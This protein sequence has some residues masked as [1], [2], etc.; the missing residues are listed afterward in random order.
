MKCQSVIREFQ[1]LVDFECSNTVNNTWTELSEW[2][3]FAEHKL[4]L[5][6]GSEKFSDNIILRSMNISVHSSEIILF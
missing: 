3:H 6:N 5:C 1:Y 4:N 2:Q